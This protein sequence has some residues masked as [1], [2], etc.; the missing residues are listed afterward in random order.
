[1]LNIIGFLSPVFPF[2]EKMSGIPLYVFITVL[3]A[4]AVFLLLFIPKTI[5]IISE[6][7]A[8]IY[9]IRKLKIEAGTP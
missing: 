9:G 8:I 6:T 2:V 1:M 3:I 7:R 5:L 4:T